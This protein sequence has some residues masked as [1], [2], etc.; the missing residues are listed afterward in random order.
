MPSPDL[1]TEEEISRLV[2]AFYATV[3]RDAMLGPIFAAHVKDWDSHLPKMVD[4]WS[5]VLRRT[6][7]YRG[8]PMPAHVALPGLTSALFQRWLS[9]FHAGTAAQ[10][11][12]ALRERA[13]EMAE[14]IAQSLWYGYQLHRR[15]DGLPDE[16]TVP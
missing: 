8:T 4:F 10:P 6:A 1:C 11:N 3:H 15:P 16:L 7:R 13:D 12:T 14:R 9:L 2:H 5:S